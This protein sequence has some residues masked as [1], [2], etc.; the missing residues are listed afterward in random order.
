MLNIKK[1]GLLKNFNDSSKIGV[2]YIHCSRR[3][4]FCTLIDPLKKQVKFS[5]SSGVSEVSQSASRFNNN[6]FKSKILTQYFIQKIKEFGFDKLRIVI[7]GLGTARV[8]LISALR[9]SNLQIIDI[10]DTTL[11]PHNGCRGPKQRRKKLR[12]RLSFKIKRLVTP[13]S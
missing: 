13:S 1:G 8:V 2:I 11:I 7:R 10:Q 5:C 4:V 9:N 3:N 6:Y 12:T